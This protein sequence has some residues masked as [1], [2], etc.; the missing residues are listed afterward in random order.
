MRG[1]HTCPSPSLRYDNIPGML[2]TLELSLNRVVFR[3]SKLPSMHRLTTRKLNKDFEFQAKI[4]FKNLRS[5]CARRSNILG[6]KLI[7][8]QVSLNLHINFVKKKR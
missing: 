7:A 1:G 2:A 5:K 4:I 8:S 6:A 3:T